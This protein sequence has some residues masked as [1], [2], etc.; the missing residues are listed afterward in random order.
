MPA[1][2]DALADEPF[3]SL[4]GALGLTDREIEIGGLLAQ[5]HS[6]KKTAE[7]LVISLSTVQ[8]HTRNLYRKCGVNSRQGLIDMLAEMRRQG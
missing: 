7:M 1:V 2:A 4:H 5:G 8:S 3:R 6:Y